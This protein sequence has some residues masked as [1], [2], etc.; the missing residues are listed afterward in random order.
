MKLK[1]QNKLLASSMKLIGRVEKGHVKRVTYNA[2]LLKQKQL[3]FLFF[4]ER[5]R[6]IDRLPTFICII[7]SSLLPFI[8]AT[9][10]IH[11]QDSLWIDSFYYVNVFHADRTLIG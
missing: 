3:S 9:S 11:N 5:E 6:V 8:D 1:D 7:W 4:K 2:F 10:S